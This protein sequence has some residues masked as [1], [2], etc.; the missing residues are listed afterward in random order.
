MSVASSIMRSIPKGE[1]AVSI[2]GGAEPS[3]LIL[4]LNSGQC[5]RPAVVPSC[6]V[7]VV[8]GLIASV[9]LSHQFVVKCIRAP[10]RSSISNQLPI[11][12]VLL[13]MVRK[14]EQGQFVRRY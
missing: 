2:V 5:V 13:S 8:G 6:S 10:I 9:A 11:L 14:G 3:G 7:I 1:A 12:D 4:I